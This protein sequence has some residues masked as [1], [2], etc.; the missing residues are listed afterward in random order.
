MNKTEF[1]EV[2][3]AAG[4]DARA[5]E[6]LE[7]D[8]EGMVEAATI[9]VEN[10]AGLPTGIASDGC[11]SGLFY[12]RVIYTAGDAD[13]WAAESGYSWTDSMTT[14]GDEPACDPSQRF[15]SLE[16]AVAGAV[17]DAEGMAA[18]LQHEV[19]EALELAG[20]QPIENYRP[21]GWGGSAY[22]DLTPVTEDVE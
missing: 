19:E 21:S 2:V 22:F 20:G 1:F 4:L 14:D 5:V 16:E 13:C 10:E 15:A 6:N 17:G 11:G 18:T 12:S 3:K 7:M 9:E 8:A